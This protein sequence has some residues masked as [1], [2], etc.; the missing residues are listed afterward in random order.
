[1]ASNFSQLSEQRMRYLD[2]VD[3]LVISH[4]PAGSRSLLDVGAGDGRRALRIAQARGLTQLVLLEPSQGMQRR[5]PAA[6]QFLAWRA[7]QLDSLKGSFDVIVCLWNVLGHIFPNAARVEVMRQFARLTAP[8]GLIFVDVNHRYNAALYGPARTGFRFLQD[9]I[10]PSENN[11]DVLVAWNIAGVKCRVPGHVFTHREVRALAHA[12]G[13]TIDRRF[14]IDYKTGQIRRFGV[15]G[16]LLYLLHPA[17]A[18]VE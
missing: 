11:G 10:R 6:P 1:M 7:E 16:N 3:E 4:V 5:N 15:Q 2:R 8:R 9:R 18:A 13:L 14:V 17:S 12:A